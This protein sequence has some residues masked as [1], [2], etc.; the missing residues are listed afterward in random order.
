MTEM[1]ERLAVV[2]LSLADA[3]IWTHGMLPHTQPQHVH[4]SEL[5]LSRHRR[6]EGHSSGREDV[7][8]DP[9]FYEEIIESIKE[10]HEILLFG[11]GKGKA[12]AMLKFCQY[13]ERKHP[14]IAQRFVDALDADLADLTNDQI[15][16]HARK[17]QLQELQQS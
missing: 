13:V 15:L 7:Y 3:R 16:D 4:I 14:E 9:D 2:A 5:H 6:H 10:S 1:T 8:D 11:H 17:W 12:S